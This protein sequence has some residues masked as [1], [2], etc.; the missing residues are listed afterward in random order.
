MCVGGPRPALL[1]CLVGRSVSERS[2]QSR[3][4]ETAGFLMGYMFIESVEVTFR[5]SYSAF[6][7]LSEN[8]SHSLFFPP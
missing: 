8:R 7:G 3:L 5:S 6:S 1:C 2:Q 4:V